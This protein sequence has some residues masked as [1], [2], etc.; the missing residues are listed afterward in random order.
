MT[1]NFALNMMNFALNM[2]NFALNM[3]NFAL[4]MM[5]FAL[6]MMNFVLKMMIRMQTARTTALEGACRCRS[7]RAERGCLSYP[8]DV[9]E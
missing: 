8:E 2:M 1:M 5:T 4:N 6:N 9:A 3:M 7:E